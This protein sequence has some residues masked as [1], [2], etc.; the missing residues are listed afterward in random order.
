MVFNL[1]GARRAQVFCF[2]SGGPLRLRWIRI[3]QFDEPVS[4][5]RILKNG[6][7]YETTVTGG[8]AHSIVSSDF[9]YFSV[10]NS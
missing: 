2:T 1:D 8:N 3:R 5:F 9:H 6:R 7:C 10:L 4:I